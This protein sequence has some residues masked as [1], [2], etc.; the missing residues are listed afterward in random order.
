MSDEI[1]SLII[2][3]PIKSKGLSGRSGHKNKNMVTPADV[4]EYDCK[5]NIVRII[6]DFGHLFDQV[7][8]STWAG[9]IDGWSPPP[10][11][12]VLQ[13]QD[14]G[15][16]ADGRW[17]NDKAKEVNINNKYRKLY[18]IKCAINS[19]NESDL[20]RHH[21]LCIRT[22]EYLDLNEFI[23]CVCEYRDKGH[24]SNDLLFV[25]HRRDSRGSIGEHYISGN[26]CAV[27][28]LCDSLLTLRSCELHGSIHKEIW[29]K[30]AF[31]NNFDA[32]GVRR[33][34]Y[35]PT[36]LGMKSSHVKTIWEYEKEKVFRP[37][38]KKLLA[39]MIWRGEAVT[40][41][42][43]KKKENCTFSDDLLKVPSRGSSSFTCYA[44]MPMFL[45]VNFRELHKYQ[46][47]VGH[48]MYLPNRIRWVLQKVCRRIIGGRV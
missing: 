27:E 25:T 37:L 47:L 43:M 19:L 34:Y 40:N 11:L 10:K 30:H 35:F 12:K 42:Y 29:L 5:A 16:E 2:Q 48:E 13:L 4:V 3:G 17:S 24:K 28:A 23:R 20:N 39:E 7:V 32:I 44:F 38:S 46:K 9:E 31:V 22:D 33:Q 21:V 41:D 6:E 14:D 18:G 8:L 36:G 15:L 1:F 26:I 45:A